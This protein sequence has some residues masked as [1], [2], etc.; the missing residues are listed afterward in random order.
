M[1]NETDPLFN[2]NLAY[3]ERVNELLRICSDFS[4][5]N[6]YV[7]WY[8]TI[9]AIY[10]E[11]SALLN[12]EEK[13]EYRELN[14]YCNNIKLRSECSNE[15]E[16]FLSNESI[17]YLEIL[18]EFIKTKMFEKKLIISDKKRIAEL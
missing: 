2:M 9:R 11:I 13:E 5:K 6:N 4:I 16:V 7:S 1:K 12:E 15:K 8:N 14:D 3:L 18:D 10:R 17:M